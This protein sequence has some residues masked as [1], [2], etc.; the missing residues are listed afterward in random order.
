MTSIEILA[1]IFALFILI[2]LIVVAISPKKWI[3]FSKAAL[4]NKGPIYVVYII[5]TIIVGYFVLNSL[6][7][8]EVG[9]VMLLVSLLAALSFLPYAK[10]LIVFSD[11]IMN[12]VFKKSWLVIIIWIVLAL[13]ILYSVFT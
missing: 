2:K 3:T 4:R 13:W 9:A 10:K 5:L 7:I 12:G 6:S 8:V 1:L 11:E